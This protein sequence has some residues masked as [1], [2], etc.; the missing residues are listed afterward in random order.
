MKLQIEIESPSE[1]LGMAFEIDW[2]IDKRVMLTRFSGEVSAEDLRQHGAKI[3]TYIQ[4]GD[5][6]LFLIVD[7]LGMTQYPTNLKEA[8]EAMGSNRPRSGDVEWTIIVTDNRFIN[9][10][11]TIVAN[12][13]KIS[14]RACKSMGEAEAFIGHHAEELS[15]YLET[16]P[17]GEQVDSR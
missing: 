2:Y 9:F 11:G 16:R 3:E 12:V 4:E 14:V 1:M 7:T 8:L 17:I 6:P 15:P 5:K 10:V 13:F